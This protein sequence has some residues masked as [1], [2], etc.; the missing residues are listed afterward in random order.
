LSRVLLIL[1]AAWWDSN[2][3][4]HPEE[5]CVAEKILHHCL[6]KWDKQKFR[7]IKKKV[8]P[9]V[10]SKINGKE[11][12]ININQ[13]KLWDESKRINIVELKKSARFFKGRDLCWGGKN[14]QGFAFFIRLF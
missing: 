9:W 8:D 4:S 12:K 13:P 14:D 10:T 7:S 3:Q 1:I 11:T 2:P 6:L 5:G